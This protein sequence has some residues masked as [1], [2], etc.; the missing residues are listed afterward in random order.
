MQ[1][2]SGDEARR[3]EG[4]MH[5]VLDTLETFSA[6]FSRVEQDPEIFELVAIEAPDADEMADCFGQQRLRRVA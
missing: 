4:V 3:L 1:R 6:E 2:L 5:A